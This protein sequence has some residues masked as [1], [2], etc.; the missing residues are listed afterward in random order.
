LKIFLIIF[1]S[2]SLYGRINPFFP[3]DKN[4]DI[5]LTSN[6]IKHKPM[7]QKV[8][9]ALPTY[10]RVIKKVTIEYENLDA[11]IESKSI[12]LNNSIDWH[13]PKVISQNNKITLQKEIKSHFHFI[14]QKKF[15]KFY[16]SS[17]KL[18]IV[19]KDKILRNFLLVN[20]HRIVID[21][22][23]DTSF[24]SL[25]KRDKNSRF[26]KVRLGNHSGYYRAVIELDGYYKYKTIKKPYGYLINLI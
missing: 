5:S 19:T 2:I 23:R 12:T 20:P 10:A 22:K 3:V 6:Q 4:T 11:S 17:K 26:K 8:T 1:L 15:I 7:L 16:S 9:I 25:S 21:F 18:K 14:I 24:N 13:K